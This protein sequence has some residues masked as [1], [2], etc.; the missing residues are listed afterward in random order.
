MVN[1]D[2]VLALGTIGALWFAIARLLTSSLRADEPFDTLEGHLA[3]K[4]APW[5]EPP[6][7]RTTHK[8]LLA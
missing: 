1:V 3:A 6:D 4:T 7:N 2:L 5:R 8:D